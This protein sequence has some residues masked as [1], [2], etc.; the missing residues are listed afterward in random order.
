VLALLDKGRAGF[1]VVVHVDDI[2][3]LVTEYA[4]AHPELEGPIRQAFARQ[5][6]EDAPP[7][8]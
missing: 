6:G 4:V 7:D 3:A 8:W 5:R 2:G 1:L